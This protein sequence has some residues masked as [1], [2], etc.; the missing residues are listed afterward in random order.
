MRALENMIAVLCVALLLIV[1][2]AVQSDNYTKCCE[3]TAKALV[4]SF[5]SELSASGEITRLSY[6]LYAERLYE[7]GYQGEFSVTITEYETATDGSI[8]RYV[9][10][11]D[12][13]FEK[14]VNEGSYN[15]PDGSCVKVAVGST[16]ER[17]SRS[18]RHILTSLKGFVKVGYVK[19]GLAW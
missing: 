6:N 5:L 4:D 9:T 1:L 13:I 7:I 8:H 18:F 17:I 15:C 10:T 2:V 14:I 16:D 3:T 11:W 12:E 19:G